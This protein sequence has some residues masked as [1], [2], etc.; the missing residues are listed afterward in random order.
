M[1]LFAFELKSSKQ[2]KG[3]RAD[4]ERNTEPYQ[5]AYNKNLTI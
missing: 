1:K 5:V 3:K 4:I 2:K